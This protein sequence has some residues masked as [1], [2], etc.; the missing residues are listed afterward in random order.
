MKKFLIKYK[1]IIGI[2][3]VVLAAGGGYWYVKSSSAPAFGQTTV[4]KG[5][6]VESV[7]EAGTVDAENSA[8][9][10]FQ[11][12]GEIASVNVSEG[13]QVA[14]GTVLATL[15]SSQLN[16]AVTQAQAGVATAQAQL[17]QLQSGTR[18]E[19]L[20]IDQTAVTSANQALS[21]AVENA[22]SASED[23]VTNQLDNMFSTP[24]SNNP[25][26]LVPSSNSQS[27]NTIQS[28]RVV[29]GDALSK[30]YAALNAT[31]TTVVPATL[32]ATADT[33]LLG[34][35]RCDPE[36]NGARSDACPI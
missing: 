14:A 15:N 29:I 11:E 32:S 13:S 5:N 30:W 10:S 7:D 12:G 9:V 33:A 18:P 25:I 34:G 31:S 3:V 20:Q 22:Y 16:A 23:A 1:V 4:Q 2:V 17:A 28:Q 36:C 27:V 26:F 35:E 8:A 6:I 24:Q 19:Q 21:I